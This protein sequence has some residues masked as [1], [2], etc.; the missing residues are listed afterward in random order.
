ML[1]Q[2][3]DRQSEADAKASKAFLDTLPRAEIVRDA[4]L[5][6]KPERAVSNE[7]AQGRWRLIVFR[8]PL[9]T[10]LSR[11]WVYHTALAMLADGL[12]TKGD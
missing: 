11:A 10:E 5:R 9:L 3:A 7:K 12:D 1:H 6:R 2:E 4:A 8:D